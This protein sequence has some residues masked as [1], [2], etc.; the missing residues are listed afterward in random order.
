VEVLMANLVQA[1]L[2]NKGVLPATAAASPTTPP[3]A[4]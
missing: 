4:P 1:N 2:Q 3:A